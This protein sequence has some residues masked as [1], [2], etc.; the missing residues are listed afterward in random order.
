MYNKR[1]VSVIVPVYQA[2]KTLDTCVQSILAQSFADFELIL[3]DDGSTDGSAGLCD[4]YTDSRVHVLHVANGG[5]ASARNKGISTAS[6]EWVCFV[7]SDDA[8]APSYLSILISLAEDT[9]ADI[10]SCAY[11][12][13]ERADIADY[14]SFFADKSVRNPHTFI[15]KGNE[16]TRALLYQKGFISAPWGMI[17][18]RSLWQHVSFP[19]GT[20]AEDMGTIYRLFLEASVIA[21][22][23]AVL[24]GYVMDASNTVFSTQSVRNPDYYRHSRH[25]LSYIRKRHPD[26]MKAAASRHLS[27]CFQILSETSPDTRDESA[28]E[29]INKIY[30]DIRSVRRIVIKDPK[31]RLRN[32]AAAIISYF[33]ISFMHK[34]LYDNYVK[35]IPHVSDRKIT[36]I[37][38]QGRCDTNGKAVGHAPKVLA[39]YCDMIYAP[40]GADISIYAPDV[41]LKEL[42]EDLKDSPGINTHVLFHNIVMKSHPALSDRIANKFRMFANIRR[43]LK[44]SD[45]SVLWFFNVEFYLFLYLALFGN[46]HKKIAVTMFLDGYHGGVIASVKQKIFETGQ[47]KIWRCISAGP[48]FTFKNMPSVFIPDYVCDEGLYSRYRGAGKED[49]AVCLG[50]MDKGKQLEELV[51]VFSRMSYKL[52]IAGRFYDK[53]RISALRKASGDNIEIRDEYLST[54]EYLA[55]LSHAS[56]AVLP[57]NE[58]NYAFQT[59]G[60]MQEALF[61]DTIVLTHKDILE[62]NNIPGVA[63]LSYDDINDGMLVSNASNISRNREILAEYDRLRKEVYSK[64]S[65]TKKIRNSLSV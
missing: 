52:I 7:D 25:M 62:G 35:K 19:E 12:K 57:Y 60:V 50:T 2:Y 31:A 36:M 3:V 10:V 44:E 6:G 14:V 41:I 34:L 45:A 9:N 26:C 20:A 48:S 22:T 63:Y 27:A 58:S 28:K 40:D 55:L 16:G 49:Y 65:I 4:S 24:Y 29:L 47:K 5:A 46:N 53:E 64:D 23:D 1:M 51:K 30:A 13:C 8:I 21:R 42:P 38:Y 43:S 32:R 39:E 59:S 33:N 18:K 15:Y 37:E 11:A 56:Y 61:T 17:S 54:E